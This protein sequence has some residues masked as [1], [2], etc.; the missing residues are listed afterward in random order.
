MCEICSK[1]TIET[2]KR[3]TPLLLAW[4]DLAHCSGVAIADIEKVNNGWDVVST[5]TVY[6]FVKTRA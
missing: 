6:G 5:G 1:L 3:R 2:P 4:I